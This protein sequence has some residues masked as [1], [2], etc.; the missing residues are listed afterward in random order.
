MREVARRVSEMTTRGHDTLVKGA[1]TIA[2]LSN[3]KCIY[4]KHIVEAA[5]LCDHRRMREFLAAQ[6]EPVS[7]GACGRQVGSRLDSV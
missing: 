3:S 7:C 5:D 1:R 2:D 6:G 4:K